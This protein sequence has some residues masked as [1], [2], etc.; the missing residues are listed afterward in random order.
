M[1]KNLTAII[2]IV[3]LLDNISCT[4]YNS[5]DGQS[6]FNLSNE[7]MGF[8]KDTDLPGSVE[9][10]YRADVLNATK[11]IYNRATI[12]MSLEFHLDNGQILT[13]KDI[14]STKLYGG[15]AINFEIIGMFQPNQTY[16]L[17]GLKSEPVSDE[18]V[19]YPVKS[20]IMNL[21]M[22]L[23]DEINGRN[24]KVLIKSEDITDKWSMVINN[25]IPDNAGVNNDTT[26]VH[27]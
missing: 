20:V 12:Y 2:L 5:T 7:N 9:F 10:K 27:Q 14:S 25:T 8:A 15:S 6:D 26:T 13:D 17:A 23:Q 21:S 19:K 18:Y 3:L 22:E 11:N 1:K 24:D 4:N 16:N